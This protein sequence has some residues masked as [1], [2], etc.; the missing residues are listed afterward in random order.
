MHELIKKHVSRVH[1]AHSIR[2]STIIVRRSCHKKRKHIATWQG[3]LEGSRL[4]AF[5][6]L[7]VQRFSHVSRF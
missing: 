6:L 3:E 7:D 4:H 5:E 1:M 2:N